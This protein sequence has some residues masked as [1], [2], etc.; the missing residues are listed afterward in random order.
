MKNIFLFILFFLSATISAQSIYSIDSS[1]TVKSTYNKL[2]K[3]YPF[4][5]IYI[6]VKE[7]H[8]FFILINN[9]NK[10]NFQ[11]DNNSGIG[12]SNVKNRLDLLYRGK[13]KLDLKD[14]G[15]I[16]KAELNLELSC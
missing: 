12:L 11:Q 8:L 1:Y 13:Y 6:E 7:Q 15:S 4:I 9:Y 2:I 16:F 10:K 5:K 3:K 14:D